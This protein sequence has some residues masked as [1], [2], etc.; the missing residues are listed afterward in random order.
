VYFTAADDA[1]AAEAERRPGGPL[2]W[3]EVTG[4]RKAGLFRKEPV[5]TELGPAYEGFEAGEYDP[6]VTMGTLEA[7]LTGQDN[8]VVVEDPR[9][10]GSPSR[11]ADPRDDRGVVT[12]TDALRDALVDAHGARLRE[13]AAQ[14][15]RTEELEDGGS[16]EDHVGFLRRLRG[17]ARSSAA[18]SQKLYCYFAV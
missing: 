14:W 3:P 16:V 7:L 12:V 5:V 9:Q 13:V 18:G 11:D 1:A 8:D 15:G 6:V 2:G 17:L 10:G 4:H